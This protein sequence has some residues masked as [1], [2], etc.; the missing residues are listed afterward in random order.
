MK[1]WK[2]VLTVLTLSSKVELTA[3][4]GP[5]ESSLPPGW[6]LTAPI[7]TSILAEKGLIESSLPPGWQLTAPIHTS[8]LAE[9]V[10]IS[11]VCPLASS[12]Q[13]LGA[14]HI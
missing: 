4:Q 13:H 8:I 7:D 3:G 5:I 1:K 2:C 10:D 6:Q 12:W 9:K 11:A 14:V